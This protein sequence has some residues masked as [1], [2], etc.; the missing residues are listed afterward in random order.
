MSR[1]GDLTPEEWKAMKASRALAR[2]YLKTGGR[3]VKGP[4]AGYN[5]AQKRVLKRM[6]QRD[7]Q[8]RGFRARQRAEAI[9]K[10]L[11]ELNSASAKEKRQGMMQ[12]LSSAVKGIFG[13]GR[14]KK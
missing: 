12:R 7:P 9:E 10:R 4:F 8:L 5:R 14:Q 6:E 2:L 13:R 3:Y 11:E 1:K